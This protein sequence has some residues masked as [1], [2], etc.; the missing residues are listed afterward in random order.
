[1]EVSKK[2]TKYLLEQFATISEYCNRAERRGPAAEE[3]EMVVIIC[4][5]FEHILGSDFWGKAKRYKIARSREEC[6]I[7]SI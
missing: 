2:N 5:T 3:E 1:M 7:P 6:N 4:T